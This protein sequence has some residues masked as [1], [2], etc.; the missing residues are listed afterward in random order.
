MNDHRSKLLR[1]TIV[2]AF[3]R[4]LAD[5]S[6]RDGRRTGVPPRSSQTAPD[7]EVTPGPPSEGALPDVGDVVVWHNKLVRLLG[8]GM[9]GKVYVAQRLDVPEHQVALKLLPRSLYAGRNVERELVMLATVGHPHVVQLKDH[10][11]TPDYV[12][13]T[14]PVYH[15][16]TLAERLEQKGTLSARQA[17]D[18]FLP[19]AR[20]LEALHAAGLRHQDVKPENIFLAIFGGRVH[21]ILLDLG[22]A[23]EKDA[24]FVAGTALYGSPEQVAVLSGLPIIQP[25]CEKMDT[26][27]LAATLL[28]ALVGP[29][30]FPG[31]KATDRDELAQAQDDR[32]KDPIGMGALPEVTGDPRDQLS[33]SFRLWLS[34]LPEDRP[35]MKELA[36]QLEV[37][38]EPDAEEVRQE[39]ARRARQER[40]IVRFKLVLGG[41]LL[42]GAV[43]GIV[44]YNQR[45]TLR[46]ASD[47]D[48]ARSAGA[49]SFDQLS[50][51]NAAH[52]E[53]VKALADCR[54]AR[55]RATAEHRHQ[56]DEVMRSGSMSQQDHA[57]E[58]TRF[59]NRLKT[60]EESASAAKRSSD[61]EVA[62]LLHE[63]SRE[64]A[65]LTAQRAEAKR[66][67]DAQKAQLAAL[68]AERDQCRSDRATCL[69]E[70]DTLRAAAASKADRSEQDRTRPGPA[71]SGSA[72]A[73]PAPASSPPSRPR[74]RGPRPRSH[75]R[76]RLPRR[77]RSSRRR[78]PRPRSRRGEE[79]VERERRPD[80]PRL[81]RFQA[82]SRR[83]RPPRPRAPPAPRGGRASAAPRPRRRR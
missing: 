79:R 73:G 17:Y 61:E 25:L 81:S 71:A 6:Q 72:S 65:T 45:E 4:T 53:G 41:M 9:F 14:M 76:R 32:T 15:G 78:L 42:I 18:I 2:Q 48:R 58:T 35:T 83:P 11:T 68:L 50:T 80:C 37:L 3:A 55:E 30:H 22:V 60:C 34:F 67:A 74:R 1:T 44:A 66:A 23:A 46:I 75:P 38:L 5:P 82:P 20:G 26:Y 49:K 62:R 52:T 19:V 47:L 16:E 56:L 69:D 40:T 27:A 43:G 70:R 64:K 8:Q 24:T 10:G 21:P 57:R 13:L 7:T 12:W 77:R 54:A 29:K 59:N 39:E 63:N 28:M 51:C 31:E 36:E 33:A